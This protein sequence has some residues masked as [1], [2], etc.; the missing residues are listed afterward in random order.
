MIKEKDAMR[1]EMSRRVIYGSEDFIDKVTT[2]YNVE[3]VIKLKGRPKKNRTVPFFFTYVFLLF[4][5][6]RRYCRWIFSN[7]NN[8]TR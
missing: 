4:R 8:M 2:E 5:R 1:G 3:A 6:Q 7:E